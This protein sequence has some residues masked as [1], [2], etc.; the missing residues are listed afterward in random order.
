MLGSTTKL[1]VAPR[2]LELSLEAQL[3]PSRHNSN[4]I[5]VDAQ[6]KDS[7]MVDPINKDFL[8]VDPKNK[9]SLIVD[10]HNEDFLIVG[11]HNK[12]IL[13]VGIHNKASS[14]TSRAR[15]VARGATPALETQLQ[16]WISEKCPYVFS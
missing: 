15:V 16:P 1:R 14:C 10:P 12:G 7:L 6:H 9:D 2:K 4:S 13:I 8:I 11:I 5:G 3:R